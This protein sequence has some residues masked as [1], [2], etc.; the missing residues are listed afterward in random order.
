[1]NTI[2]KARYRAGQLYRIATSP[3]RLMPDFII[4]GGQRCGTTSLYNY[5]MEYPGIVPASMKEVHYFDYHFD[6]PGFWY[7]AQFPFTFNKAYIEKVRKLSFVT[8][9]ASPYYLFHPQSPRRVAKMLPAVKLIALLRNPIDRAYSQHWL[10]FKLGY[11]TLSFEEAIDQEEKRL[12]G[13]RERMLHDERY[14]SYSY[15]H[16][17]YLCRGIYMDQ[18]QHWLQFFPREQLLILKSEDLYSNP[19][20][21]VRQTLEFLGV[22]VNEQFIKQKEFKN[23][24]EPTKEG[25]KSNEKPPKMKAETRARLIDYFRPHNARLYEFLGRDLGWE[26]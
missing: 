26:K 16:Y 6:R 21:V 22:P 25:Y 17:S 24:R 5:L 2:E 23:Y 10:E 11:D 13:E 14:E 8:G 20:T 4:I 19:A 9:E 3:V 18:L 1:M 7:R 15:R 12:A